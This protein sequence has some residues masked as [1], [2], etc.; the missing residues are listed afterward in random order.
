MQKKILRISALITTAIL[1]VGALALPLS[2]KDKKQVTRPW[3]ALG[4]QTVLVTPISL[5]EAV[6]H[7]EEYGNATH[8]GLTHNVGDGTMSLVTGKIL[9]GEGTTTAANGDTLHWV[10]NG[11]EAVYDGGTGR[12]ENAYGF[13]VMTILSQEMVSNGDGTLTVTAVDQLEGELTY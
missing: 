7:N 6:Y 12:F 8:L 2:A 3:K 1:L 4:L 13:L 10:W 5:T 11:T 9:T